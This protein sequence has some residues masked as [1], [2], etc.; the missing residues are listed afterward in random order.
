MLHRT[1][2]PHT[3]YCFEMYSSNL[4]LSWCVH[5]TPECKRDSYVIYDWSCT[6]A[7]H[8]SQKVYSQ[9]KTSWDLQTIHSSNRCTPTTPGHFRLHCVC[10]LMTF[11]LHNDQR[12]GIV[13]RTWRQPVCCWTRCP[14]CV[15][16]QCTGIPAPT[17]TTPAEQV[18]KERQR[19]ESR[20][21]TS[22]AQESA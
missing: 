17:H 20:I 14:S 22:A 1:C 9:W 3:W 12:R 21:S 6:A 4:L 11:A 13:M 15:S 8:I 7:M 10:K 19:G 2:H 16:A 5:L 18:S